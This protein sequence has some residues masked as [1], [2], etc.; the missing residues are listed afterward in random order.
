MV[1][2]SLLVACHTSSE[3]G[4]LDSEGDPAVALD[5][6]S[7]SGIK[8]GRIWTYAYTDGL[9]TDGVLTSTLTD[10]DGAAGSFTWV[11]D[12]DAGDGS[13]H[14]EIS[15]TCTAE[16]WFKSDEEGDWNGGW[17]Q[18]YDPPLLLVPVDLSTDSS[19]TQVE[20]LTYTT[21]GYGAQEG[22]FTYNMAGGN[23]YTVETPV[24]DFDTIDV[25]VYITETT[26]RW[27]TRYAD[28]TG[29][30]QTVMYPTIWTLESVTE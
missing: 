11:D 19:W 30:V 7:Y 1:L 24:G 27:D 6:P 2:L 20:H 18:E 28:G 23:G 12:V 9:G 4:P 25:Q 22:D 10:I 17:S 5:C 29:P 8:A 13:Y 16:G 21:A 3:S 15:C 14:Q 26:G